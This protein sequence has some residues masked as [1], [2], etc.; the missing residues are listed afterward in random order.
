MKIGD[1]V[2]IKRGTKQIIGFGKIVSDYQHDPTRETYHSVRKVD[3]IS[4]GEWNV[5]KEPIHMKTLTNITR[6]EDY[7]E[8]LLDK[9][10]KGN[11]STTPPEGNKKMKNLLRIQLSKSI[12]K[13]S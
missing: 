3:W 1:Y 8:R 5:D 12:Q 9:V 7:V 13:F 2:F 10:G 4:T 6:Y 11:S